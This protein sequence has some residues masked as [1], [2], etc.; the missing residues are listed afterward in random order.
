MSA[1]FSNVGDWLETEVEI[2]QID[3][4]DAVKQSIIRDFKDYKIKEVE[5]VEKPNADALFEIELT[6]K[7]LKSTY[8]AVY[9]KS[10]QLIEKEISA[11]NKEEKDEQ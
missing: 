1:N 2:K 7:K 8:E 9:S 3:L 6:N 11:D 5:S 10:G 4:P